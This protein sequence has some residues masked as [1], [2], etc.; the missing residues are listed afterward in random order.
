[1]TQIIHDSYEKNMNE[2]YK[3]TEIIN[4]GNKIEVKRKVLTNTHKNHNLSASES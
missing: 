2:N 3:H 1:M 4:F